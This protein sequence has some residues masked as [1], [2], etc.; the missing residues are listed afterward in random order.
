MSEEFR[1]GGRLWGKKETIW[2]P[3]W[4]DFGQK[5]SIGDQ[6][7]QWRPQFTTL[8]VEVTVVTNLFELENPFVIN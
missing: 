2:R 7:L 6:G 3:I 4:K 5:V 8:I 1:G